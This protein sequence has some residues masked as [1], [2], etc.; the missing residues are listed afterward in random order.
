MSDGC[1]LGKE[2]PVSSQRNVICIKCYVEARVQ[3]PT[4]K[5]RE[6]RRLLL[7]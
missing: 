2:L 7:S 3:F 4:R 6:R 5:K 1:V